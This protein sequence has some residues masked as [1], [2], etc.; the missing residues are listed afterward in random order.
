[1]GDQVYLSAKN[2]RITGSRKLLPRFL[3]PFTILSRVGPTAY[4]LDLSRS[5][6]RDVH[7]VFHVSLLKPFEDNGLA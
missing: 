5:A 4:R 1:M 3:G 2:I 7:N 6:L